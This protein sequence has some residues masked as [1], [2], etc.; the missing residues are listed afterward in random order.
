[1][2]IS[3]RS[4]A[5]EQQ[6]TDSV[7]LI[8]EYIPLGELQPLPYA[9]QELKKEDF[10]DLYESIK[11]EGLKQSF[12]VARPPDSED[13]VL[14]AG[15]NSR[16]EVVQRLHV[17]SRGSRFNEVP[18]VVITWPGISTAKLSHL[19]TNDVLHNASFIERAKAIM[20]FI[21]SNSD[22]PVNRTTSDRGVSK[23][24]KDHGYPLYRTTYAAMKYAVD[25]LEKYL[26]LSLAASLSTLDVKHIQKLENNLKNSWIATGKPESEFTQVFAEVASSCDHEDLD[27]ETLQS[28]LSEEISRELQYLEGTR[29]EIDSRK[30]LGNNKP[31]AESE[32]PESN[33]TKKSARTNTVAEEQDS[34]SKEDCISPHEQDPSQQIRKLASDIANQF[35]LQDCIS[36]NSRGEFGFLVLELPPED[37]SRTARLVWEYLA[38]FSGSSEMSKAELSSIVSTDSR[39]Y[40]EMQEH[41]SSPSLETAK[42]IDLSVMWSIDSANFEL[43]LQ[44]WRLVFEHTTFRP[45]VDIPLELD[46]FDSNERIAA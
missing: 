9:S 12:V 21:D 14:I 25:H 16:L 20:N 37:S 34:H 33:F 10:E 44:L 8:E 39:L 1:M 26:P 13:Y 15:G 3:L 28:V 5:K 2:P 27:Y 46:E 32:P 41:D 31:I 45:N 30:F 42:E 38:N 11:E 29:K 7:E 19:I 6:I 40:Q 17:E 18:C 23:F 36:L 22:L 35:D 43:L 4:S 24:F